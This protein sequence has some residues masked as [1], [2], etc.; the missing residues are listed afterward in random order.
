MKLQTAKPIGYAMAPSFPSL[1]GY[2]LCGWVFASHP[3][4]VSFRLP[5]ELEHIRHDGGLSAQTV[6]AM[7]LTRRTAPSE[8]R[9]DPRDL[10]QCFA[11]ER[12]R[13]GMLSMF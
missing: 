7:R 8:V 9:G 13:Q 2:P 3:S 11:Q 4:N 12:W 6:F 10:P 5:V 1:A